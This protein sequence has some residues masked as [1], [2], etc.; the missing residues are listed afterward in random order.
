MLKGVIKPVRLK[1]Y[2]ESLGC[3]K[4]LIDSE[5]MSGL[6]T[7]QR[8]QITNNVQETDIIIVNTCAFIEDAKQESINTIIELSKLKKEGN[9]KL[10][11]VSGCLGERY[12]E[13]LALELPE[14]D[15]IIGT[16][17][18]PEIVDFVD[19]A[20]QGKK[21]IRFGNANIEI[22]ENLPRILSTPAYTA[23][24]KIA[25]GCNNYCTY[26][27]IPKLRGPY[28]SRKIENIILEVEELA[29]KGVKEIVLI[30][31]D[32]TKY[33]VDLYGEIK[34]SELLQKLCEIEPIKWIR[35]LYCYPENISDQL[36]NIIS[37]ENKICKYLDLPI[38]HCNDEILK[39][40]NRRTNKRKIISII[41]KLRKK[42]PN[43][44]IRTSLIVGF[45]GETEVQFDELK[46]FVID[47]K[48]D[49]LG[50]FTY[51]QEEDT[52]AANFPDQISEDIKQKRK[53]EIML[54]QKEISLEKNKE[55]IDNIY[56]ILIE[57]KLEGESIYTGRTM[58]DTPEV[59]GIVYI[60]TN[61]NLKP[62]SWEKVRIFDAL[63]YDLLGESIDESC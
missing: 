63:E 33:G 11:I 52:P 51:S 37:L 60:Y 6:L 14:V 17:D 35:L 10:L 46:Q 54:I 3:P 16:G 22:P 19:K 59:D 9:C 56:D 53:E 12:A 15:V 27:I 13:E 28:R 45:P 58:Y 5:I 32:T 50:V 7:Q 23:Y 20:L 40:M 41:E 55:K 24:V 25:E 29:K 34:L 38:Q 61:K 36:I 4:N 57:E 49:K 2:I 8:F 30:A 26:C 48:F 31:Q 47:L 62:G 42:I 39:K 21:V 18:F 43:I 1:I 44:Q